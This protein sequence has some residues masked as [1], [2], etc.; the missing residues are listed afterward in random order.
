[1][2][3]QGVPWNVG[4]DNAGVSKVMAGCSEGLTAVL[5]DHVGLVLV[6]EVATTLGELRTF[7]LGDAGA[8]R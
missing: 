5:G 3:R 8:R 7:T 2:R 6:G 4:A 1:M